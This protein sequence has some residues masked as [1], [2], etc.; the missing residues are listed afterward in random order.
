MCLG[1]CTPDD[2]HMLDSILARIAK[3]EALELPLSIPTAL[4]LKDRAN[5]W[6]GAHVTDGQQCPDQYCLPDQGTQ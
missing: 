5:D 3:T 2:I 4:I 1:I 6:G